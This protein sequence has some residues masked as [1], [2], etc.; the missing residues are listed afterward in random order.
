M[1]HRPGL[2]IV[3]AGLA[4]AKTAE[5]LRDRGFDGPIAL[6]GSES[7]RPYERPPL[8]KEYL[9]GKSPVEDIYVHPQT[10]Y[11]DH[12]VDLH[13]DS[14]VTGLDRQEKQVH[15]SAGGRL[16]YDRLLIATGSSP[17]RL[18][19]PGAEADNVLY[20]RT[21]QDSDRLRQAL[22]PGTQVVIVGG[23]WIGL[24]TAAAARAAGAEVTVLEQGE[25]PL[26]RILGARVAQVFADLHRQHGV[27]LRCNVTVSELRTAEGGTS[28]GAVVLAD[29]SAV[30]ADHVIVGIGAIPNIDLA[31][32]AGLHTNNGIVVDQALR[33]SDPDVFAAGD[34]AN[35]YHPFLGRHLRVEHWANA[36][37]QPPVAADAMLGGRRVYDRLPYFFTDQYDLGMEY[38]GLAEPADT[39]NVVL[40][41]GTDSGEFIAFW[42]RDRRVVAGMNVNVW[43][44]NETIQQLIS[45]EEQ[46]DPHDLADLDRSLDELISDPR[47]F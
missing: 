9:Q 23:G 20:L 21:K 47:P 22:A 35:A 28:V 38:T 25:L 18:G 5:A 19:L 4:G 44:V 46:V 26:V 37:H 6:V 11:A 2:L 24:E 33:T 40:R 16:R 41:G 7:E 14:T 8:S 30:P 13:L 3:G 36:L 15:T 43:D 12:D 45:T 39:D 10:W 31:R 1:N 17:R 42:L 29:G 34:I 27:D 32:D